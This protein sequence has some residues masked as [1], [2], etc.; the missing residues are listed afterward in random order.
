MFLTTFVFFNSLSLSSRDNQKCRLLTT[1]RHHSTR[2][3]VSCPLS[4]SPDKNIL[5]PPQHAYKTTDKPEGTYNVEKQQRIVEV[6]IACSVLYNLWADYL[7]S[8]LNLDAWWHHTGQLELSHAS[9][10]PTHHLQH[11]ITQITLM[12]CYQHNRP[13]TQVNCRSFC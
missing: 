2:S 8:D 3:S 5:S 7:T 1:F 10:A 13:I 12:L 4:F 11:K 6:W 9:N